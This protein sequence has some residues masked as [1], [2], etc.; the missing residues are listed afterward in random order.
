MARN[1][2]INLILSPNTSYYLEINDSYTDGIIGDESH[3]Y[4]WTLPGV[5]IHRDELIESPSFPA[6]S[7]TLIKEGT[8]E[9]ISFNFNEVI[10]PVTPDSD[11]LDTLLRSYIYRPYDVSGGGGGGGGNVTIVNPL[12]LPVTGTINIGN[13]VEVKNDAG[14]PL[15]VSIADGADVT[16][17]SQADAVAGTDTGTFSLISLFKRLLTQFTAFLTRIP[18]TLTGL[19]NFRTAILEPLPSGTNTIGDVTVSNEV[20]VKNDAGNPLAVSGTVTTIPSGTQDVNIVSPSPITVTGTVIPEFD[21]KPLYRDASLGIIGVQV[22][23]TAGRIYKVFATNVNGA[24]R[25]IKFYDQ[26][27]AP[28]VG[29]D[30]VLYTL[31][32]SR[33][34]QGGGT[35]DVTFEHPI[36]FTNALWV[37]ATTSAGDTANTYAGTDLI[38][39]ISYE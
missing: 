27:A 20:E 3:T 12:P 6:D 31:T 22:S 16:L 25:S 26:V 38:V 36:E 2:S 23:N 39:Q 33:V 15:A 32:V 24:E 37:A 29:V 1:I 28:T 17:G 4:T 7:F 19:G 11:A 8:N 5:S 35:L 14:N 30:P 21:P 18:A 9:S 34:G 13:E 10:A